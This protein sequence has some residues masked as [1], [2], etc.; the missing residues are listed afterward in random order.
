VVAGLHALL[1]HGH[2]P[3]QLLRTLAAEPLADV[4]VGAAVLD[5]RVADLCRLVGVDPALYDLPTPTTAQQ[6]WHAVTDLLRAAEINY[7]TRQPTATLAATWR[8]FH[9]GPASAGPEAAA[10]RRLPGQTHG[11]SNATRLARVDAA[12]DR[13]ISHAISRATAEPAEYLVGLLGPQ[14]HLEPA[15]T[16][17]E[18]A[19]RGIEDYRH[20][21]LGLPYGRPADRE[22]VDPIRRALGIRP[23]GA[24]AASY[25]D[26][27]QTGAPFNATLPF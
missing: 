25:D 3:G 17:W 26:A 19:A 4:R 24:A 9:G 16:A 7:L 8:E 20:R 6:E 10:D 12:L 15:A 22:A 27:F 13:Q 1:D 14:P 21:Q 5:R 23:D 11:T 18:Q 2:H